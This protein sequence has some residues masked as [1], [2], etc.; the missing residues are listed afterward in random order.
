M[1]WRYREIEIEDGDVLDPKD[2]NENVETYSN[3]INGFLDRDN[4]NEGQIAL[5]AEVSWN[6]DE[7]PF[8]AVEYVK[9]PDPL[10]TNPYNNG[11]PLAYPESNF[12]QNLEKDT[13]SWQQVEN[14]E[15]SIRTTSDE[16]FVIEGGFRLKHDLYKEAD[17]GATKSAVS[18]Y[19]NTH[20]GV[21]AIITV[22]GYQVAEAGPVAGSF[23]HISIPLM[24]VLPVSAGSHD[25]KMFVKLERKA[26]GLTAKWRDASEL[27]IA[28]R[29]LMVLRRMR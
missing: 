12:I 6:K 29:N 4:L 1:A 27:Y 7:G 3:E 26:I 19:L 17:D 2:W 11:V 24:G 13:Q 23:A 9:V 25:V 18:Q 14:V 20:L 16:L 28:E 22:D 5:D 10:R 8:Y 15:L 21:R